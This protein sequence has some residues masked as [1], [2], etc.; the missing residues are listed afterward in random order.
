MPQNIIA[1]LEESI[2]YALDDKVPKLQPLSGFDKV[3]L[4]LDNLYILADVADAERVASHIG[5]M[6]PV[7]DI[8]FFIH[9]DAM[10]E[11]YRK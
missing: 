11:I 3:V 7:I 5:P 8:I 10:Y 2:R 1:N 9:S 6:Y 4:I